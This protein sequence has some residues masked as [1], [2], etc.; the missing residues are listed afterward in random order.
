MMSLQNPTKGLITMYYVAIQLCCVKS[1][2]YSLS[3]Q[4]VY[5][6]VHKHLT[7]IFTN[8]KIFLEVLL[9]HAH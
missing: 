8:V 6:F 5:V 2:R 4:F 3:W 7:M 1:I 9:M